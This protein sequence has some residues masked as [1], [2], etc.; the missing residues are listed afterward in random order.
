[1][2]LIY[3]FFEISFKMT[4][5]RYDQEQSINMRPSTTAR[6]GKAATF[7]FLSRRS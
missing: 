7:A 4:V 5:I 3:V 1:M 6:N 2:P